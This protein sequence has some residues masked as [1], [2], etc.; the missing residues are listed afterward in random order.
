[1]A[2]PQLKLVKVVKVLV[3]SLLL[4]AAALFTA[5]SIRTVSLDVNVGLQLAHW[6]KTNNISLVINQQQR[7]E[8]LACFKG[9]LARK[10]T[11]RV[12]LWTELYRTRCWLFLFTKRQSGSQQSPSHRRRATPPRCVNFTFSSVKVNSFQLPTTDKVLHLSV[13][14]SEPLHRTYG[15]FTTVT[16]CWRP[17]EKCPPSSHWCCLTVSSEANS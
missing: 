10:L 9:N 2:E 16:S 7:E 1:M 4:A 12:C 3:S 15:L 5:A 6:E 8:L 14:H 13:R 17:V 11:Q